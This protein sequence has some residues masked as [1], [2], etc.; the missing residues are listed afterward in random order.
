MG[1]DK[2]LRFAEND[3]FSFMFQR[4]FEDLIDGFE[5]K[6][7]WHSEF[8]KNDNP[9]ILELGCGGG[10]YTVGLARRNPDKNYIGVDIKGARM[11]KGARQ[12]H[13]EGMKN[14]A[15]IRTQ[16]DFIEKFFGPDEVSEI[17]LTFSDPQPRNCKVNKRLS[18]RIFLS[19]YNN[20]LSEDNIIHMKTD[21]RPLFDFTLNIIE[22]DGHEKGFVSFDVYDDDAPPEVM[23]IQTHYETLWLKE[24]RTIHYL[25]FKLKR[26]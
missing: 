12:V 15:F 9:I 19:R 2:L 5:L 7:K 8:F 23:G 10:E 6:G 1:K 26:L 11:W 14:V 3:S 4:N 16:V 20:F 13:D 18:S 17:W 21:N 25:N 24:G 22:E